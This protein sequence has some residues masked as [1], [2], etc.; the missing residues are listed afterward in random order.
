MFKLLSNLAK[1]AV[2]V[3]VT[4]VAAAVDFVTLP[5]SACDPSRGMFDRTTRKLQQA[6]DALDEAVTPTKD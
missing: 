3:A 1:A 5:D 6:A 2:A 4:P